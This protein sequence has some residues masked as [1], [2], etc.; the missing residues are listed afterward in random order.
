MNN[1]KM[2]PLLMKFQ[3]LV[4]ALRGENKLKIVVEKE[5]NPRGLEM[6]ADFQVSMKSQLQSHRENVVTWR[7]WTS[8]CWILWLEL[9]PDTG[10]ARED[11]HL[12]ICNDKDGFSWSPRFF[13]IFKICYQGDDKIKF[14]NFCNRDT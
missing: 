13:F 10:P 4:Y 3:E 6:T 11:T 8:L 2:F 14:Y 5:P 7:T 1:L 12:D 9:Y